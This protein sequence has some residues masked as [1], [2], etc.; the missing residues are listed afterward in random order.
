MYIYLTTCT[1]QDFLLGKNWRQKD[2]PVHQSRRPKIMHP[3]GDT[4]DTGRVVVVESFVLY[5]NLYQIY[6]YKIE[7]YI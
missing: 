5:T 1:I 3:G 2:T 6:T 7:L 4:G